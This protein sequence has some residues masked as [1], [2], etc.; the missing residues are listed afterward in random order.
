[1]LIYM[2]RPLVDCPQR[3]YVRTWYSDCLLSR[4]KRVEMIMIMIKEEENEDT[5]T[6]VFKEEEVLANIH[7]G[8]SFK[9]N[10]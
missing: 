9:E 1:M 3:E 5:L 8:I 7:D 6:I 10:T 4:R 2:F